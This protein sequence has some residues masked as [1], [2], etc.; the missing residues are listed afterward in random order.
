[1]VGTVGDR[2][3]QCAG[4]QLKELG[5]Q[6][7]TSPRIQTAHGVTASLFM[8]DGT[9]NIRLEC[10]PYVH[11]GVIHLTVLARTTGTY[12]PSAN[13]WPDIA[14]HTNCAIFTRM[15]IPNGGG[16][17]LRAEQ[18]GA[19]SDLVVL[20]TAKIVAL[21]TTDKVPI[22]GDLPGV[23][24]LFRSQSNRALMISPPAATTNLF[25]LGTNA[26]ASAPPHS[27][28][29]TAQLEQD[30]KLLYQ[31]GKLDEAEMKL[32]E[33]LAVDPNNQAALYYLALVKRAKEAHSLGE[34]RAQN[35]PGPGMPQPPPNL[36]ARTNT[37]Y[38][39]PQ[40]QQIYEKLNSIVFEKVSFPDMTMPEVIKFLAEQ[41]QRRDP[42]QQGISFILNRTRPKMT[43]DNGQPVYFDPTTGAPITRETSNDVDLA[44]VK[45]NLDPGLTKVRLVDVLE[46]VTKTADHPINYAILD[47][48]IEFS[49]KPPGAQLHTRTFKVE[50]EHVFPEPAKH[51]YNF[52]NSYQ[53]PGVRHQP[54]PRFD[55]T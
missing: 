22:L 13:G 11:D 7:M 44:A 28:V 29:L 30:G 5:I 31:L 17:I 50:S 8:G 37:I 40:R 9:N 16:G 2:V 6:P 4:T 32:K 55:G 51:W 15:N 27:G 1:M 53:C 54:N 3:N 48:G 24:R 18:A 49:I 43:S 41:T 10:V 19:G 38:T 45:V 46:A 26:D 35:V 23:G 52:Q 33:A 25:T 34:A 39:S 36:Y 42:D 12:A 21:S 20:L 14:G 47:Y